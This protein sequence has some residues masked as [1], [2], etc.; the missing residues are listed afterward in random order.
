[1]LEYYNE[2]NSKTKNISLIILLKKF[3][4]FLGEIQD[5]RTQINILDNFRKSRNQ[6][7]QLFPESISTIDF[8]EK[9]LDDRYSCIKSGFPGNFNELSCRLNRKFC[10][11]FM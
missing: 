5:H 3:Q 6:D 7:N 4:D 8:F 2:L 11:I 9:K 1:L 10:K